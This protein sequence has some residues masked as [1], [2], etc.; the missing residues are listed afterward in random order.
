MP[1]L[2]PSPFNR[3][4]VYSACSSCKLFSCSIYIGDIY[5]VYIG[6]LSDEFKCDNNKCVP[7]EYR[8]DTV[9]DCGDNS[10]EEECGK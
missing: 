6:C 9:N 1:S 5:I 10:D 2:H 4:C 3:K 7:E 8:C